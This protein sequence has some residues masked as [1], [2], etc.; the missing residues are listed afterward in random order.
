MDLLGLRDERQRLSDE[1]RSTMTCLSMLRAQH[2]GCADAD[3][4][5]QLCST[6]EQQSAMARE[7]GA[8]L[9]EIDV[10]MLKMQARDAPPSPL[11]SAPLDF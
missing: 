5:R 3:A 1:F 6:I 9:L 7:L 4:R 11:D 8:R 10:S 2:L